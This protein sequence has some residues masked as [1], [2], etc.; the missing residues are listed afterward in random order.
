M[1]QNLASPK[2]RIRRTGVELLLLDSKPNISIPDSMNKLCTTQTNEPA[3]ILRNTPE[4]KMENVNTSNS[5]KYYKNKTIEKDEI[6]SKNLIVKKSSLCN[7][8]KTIMSKEKNLSNT[9]ILPS[10]GSVDCE[11]SLKLSNSKLDASSICDTVESEDTLHK[12]E[13]GELKSTE[14]PL[15]STDKEKKLLLTEKTSSFVED[16]KNKRNSPKS[17]ALP[18]ITSVRKTRGSLKKELQLNNSN[19]NNVDEK[20]EKTLQVQSNLSGYEKKSNIDESIENCTNIEL[21]EMKGMNVD[22]AEDTLITDDHKIL[23]ITSNSTEEQLNVDEFIDSPNIKAEKIKVS[24]NALFSFV[25]SRRK[26]TRLKTKSSFEELCTGET[27]TA[28]VNSHNLPNKPAESFHNSKQQ[29]NFKKK[30]KLKRKSG[31]LKSKS[32]TNLCNSEDIDTIS[33][34]LS[35]NI[36]DMNNKLE[37]RKLNESCLE[38]DISQIQHIKDEEERNNIQSIIKEENDTQK[39]DFSS[40]NNGIIANEL[41]KKK[42]NRQSYRQKQHEENNGMS[43]ISLEVIKP[44]KE[45]SDGKHILAKESN[46]KKKLKRNNGIC[47]QQEEKEREKMNCLSK[48]YLHKK[49]VKELNI[50]N[51][52]AHAQKIAKEKKNKV[53]SLERMKKNKDQKPVTIVSSK[54]SNMKIKLKEKTKRSSVEVVVSQNEKQNE[55][56]NILNKNPYFKKFKEKDKYLSKEE[57]VIPHISEQNKNQRE[58]TNISDEHLLSPKKRKKMNGCFSKKEVEENTNILNEESCVGGKIQEK[59]LSEEKS[60]FPRHTQKKRK[61]CLSEQKNQ[62]IATKI[63]IIKNMHI[64]NWKKMSIEIRRVF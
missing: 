15:E 19:I 6:I 61:T 54:K 13:F 18:K 34:N 16:T 31:R 21:N 37:G 55:G 49:Q 11:N 30:Q 5:L 26:S 23:E 46:L 63:P 4:H 8:S 14:L 32:D 50:S 42:R 22:K 59:C 58:E 12:E 7:I 28:E 25:T 53:A 51:E 45:Q 41:I 43:D 36:Q 62:R 35:D 64:K 10:A 38:C 3:R 2:K 33:L 24:T 47:M 48:K 57:I 20:N 40:G 52:E 56:T 1:V 27:S 29:G 17:S 44:H 39:V 9:M 60:I